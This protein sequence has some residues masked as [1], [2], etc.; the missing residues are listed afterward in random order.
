[1]ITDTVYGFAVVVASKKPTTFVVP[2]DPDFM[3]LLN[4]FRCC[5]VGARDTQ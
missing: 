5:D 4:G 3:R 1:V 2:S